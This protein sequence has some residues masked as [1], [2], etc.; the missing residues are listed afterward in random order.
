MLEEDGALLVLA[1]LVLEPHSDDAWRQPRHLRQLLLHE[2]V[3]PRVG[4]VARAEGV[5]LFLVQDCSYPRRL[6]LAFV[7]GSPLAPWFS[8][9]DKK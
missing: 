1:S 9:C 4:V 7:V 5:Q 8:S 2:G 3:G 6:V